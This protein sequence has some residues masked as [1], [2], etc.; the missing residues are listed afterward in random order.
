MSPTGDMTGEKPLR[1]GRP[2]VGPVFGD[3]STWEGMKGVMD[4]HGFFRTM[5]F[6]RIIDIE[7]RDKSAD[8]LTRMIHFRASSNDETLKKWPRAFQLDIIHGV[9]AH[10]LETTVMIHNPDQIKPMELQFALHTYLACDAA[11]TKVKE[12]EGKPF[13]DAYEGLAVKTLEGSVVPQGVNRIYADTGDMNILLGSDG[14]QILVF[15]DRTLK[16]AVL[17]NPVGRQQLGDL[18]EAD[19]GKFCCLESGAI[20]NRITVPAGGTIGFREIVTSMYNV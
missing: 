1:G 15:K 19:H 16:D 4:L 14:L 13:H 2:I 18:P 12:F 17:W 3:G 11:S 8:G 20:Y 10:S 7:K 9:S 6:E 5:Q